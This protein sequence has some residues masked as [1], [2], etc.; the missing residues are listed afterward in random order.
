MRQFSLENR[1]EAAAA[2]IP[3]RK[4]RPDGHAINGRQGENVTR[5]LWKSPMNNDELQVANNELVGIHPQI[6]E[7]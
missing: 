2:R 4:R 3:E 7:R 1:T 6:R 5:E